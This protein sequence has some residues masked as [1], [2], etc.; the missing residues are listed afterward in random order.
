MAENKKTRDRLQELRA[1]SDAD[2]TVVIANA[3]KNIY[4]FRKDRLGKPIEDVKV[5]KNSRKEI[6]RALTIKRERELA[7]S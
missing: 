4:Q 2:L 1:T 5:V 6:A 7:Q 3:H